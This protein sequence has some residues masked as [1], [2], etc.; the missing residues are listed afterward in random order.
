LFTAQNLLTIGAI[1]ALRRL[2]RERDVA[3]LGVDDFPTA[4]LLSPG[5][6]V[7][8]QDPAAMGRLAA[9]L[10]LDRIAGRAAPPT[11]H[12]VPTTLVR[13]GSGEIRAHDAS[14]PPS[15]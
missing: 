10:L 14:G 4:D 12:V 11:T 7:V 9:R 15:R 6:S 13:R 5:V 2:E 3:V 8:A 1:R